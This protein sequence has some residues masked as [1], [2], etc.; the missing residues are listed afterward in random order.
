MFVKQTVCLVPPPT[1]PPVRRNRT[2]SPEL[3]IQERIER[4]FAQARRAWLRYQ[5]SRQRSVVYDYLTAVFE[6]VQCWKMLGTTR[7]WSLHALS[8]AENCRAVRTRDPVAIVIF[9]T[10]DPRVV[11]AKTRS[12]WSRC[13]RQ[14]DRFKPNDESLTSYIQAQGGINNCAHQWESR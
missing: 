6:I 9:C 12:K 1:L 13:L 10:S 4:Q 11:D 5:S 14:A 8:A 7:T 3:N 2:S